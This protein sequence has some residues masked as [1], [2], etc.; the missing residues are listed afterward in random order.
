VVAWRATVTYL[1]C[2]FGGLAFVA[3][4]R[5][6]ARFHAWQSILYDAAAFLVFLLFAV[7]ASIVGGSPSETET[8]ANGNDTGLFAPIFLSV[9]LAGRLLLV[10]PAWLGRHLRLPL[11]GRFAENL[12]MRRC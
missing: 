2:C 10:V 3:D 1:V 9:Y 11:I 8:S 4:R 6:E 12:A 5:P 7:V